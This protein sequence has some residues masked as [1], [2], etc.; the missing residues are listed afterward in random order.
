MRTGKAEV[1]SVA[2]VTRLTGVPRQQAPQCSRNLERCWRPE[3]DLCTVALKS[4]RFLMEL[5]GSK[6][7]AD[8]ETI[9][10]VDAALSWAVL[11]LMQASGERPASLPCE[12]KLQ[13]LPCSPR[14]CTRQTQK[15]LGQSPAVLAVLCDAGAKIPGTSGT[16][17]AQ[18]R[19]CLGLGVLGFGRPGSLLPPSIWPRAGAFLGFMMQEV[20]LGQGLRLSVR[21][22]RRLPKDP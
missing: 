5:E 8:R 9:Q 17:L 15:T 22:F 1:I 20:R 10:I 18:C 19:Y 11:K 6:Q 12:A 3:G 16:G 7:E 14:S 21:G 2:Q 4:N 13:T